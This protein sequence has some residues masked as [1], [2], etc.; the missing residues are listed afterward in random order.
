MSLTQ[1]NQKIRDYL[2][3]IDFNSLSILNLPKEN[4]TDSEFQLCWVNLEHQT[5]TKFTVID[6]Q[7]II[8]FYNQDPVEICIDVKIEKNQISRIYI[9]PNS[10]EYISGCSFIPIINPEK[11]EINIISSYSFPFVIGANIHKL[12]LDKTSRQSKSFSIN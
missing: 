12:C 11:I 5:G 4:N 8:G 9:Q 7:Y 1:V 2:S 3:E 10:F 6:C